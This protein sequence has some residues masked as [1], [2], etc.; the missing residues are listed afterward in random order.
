[1]DEFTVIVIRL[2]AAHILVDF[3]LQTRR[4]IDDKITKKWK[5]GWL[6]FHAFLAGLLAYVLV[7]EWQHWFLVGVVTG[8]THWL[9]DCLKV[10]FAK[11]DHTAVY[12]I[13]QLAH[14]MVL[15]FIALAV[16]DIQMEAIV[17][18][19]GEVWNPIMI[20]AVGLLLLLRPSS[21]FIQLIS[22]RWSSH[23]KEKEG[24]LPAAGAWI[25]YLERI[26]IYLFIVMGEYSAIG[27]LIAAKSIL[28]FRDDN[29]RRPT[30]EYI[31]L[32]TLLSFTIAIPVGIG[33]RF[34][35]S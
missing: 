10:Q 35:M 19:L 22:R 2:M 29:E 24:D 15:L 18:F 23:L 30:T 20:Y 31:L 26:L 13:D 32:G 11:S 3:F 9:I 4:M 17:A 21:F 25:G 12:I 1:M 8:A 27:F 34:L 6:L 5:S 7:A 33:I 14:V 16:A 28:R